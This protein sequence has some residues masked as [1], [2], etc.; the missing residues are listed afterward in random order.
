[1]K[2]IIILLFCFVYSIF[3]N[4]NEVGCL[5]DRWSEIE[6]DKAAKVFDEK[7]DLDKDRRNYSCDGYL[8]ASVI[9]DFLSKLKKATSERDVNKVAKMVRYPVNIGLDE[10]FIDKNGHQKHKSF[11][12]INE[13][14]FVNHYEEIMTEG[15]KDIIQCS[16]LSNMFVMPSQG[17]LM[18]NGELIFSRN[19]NIEDQ[20]VINIVSITSGVESHKK[21]LAKHCTFEK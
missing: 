10:T 17:I 15:V 21:W 8:T 20:V 19:F 5:K 1:M 16:S 4:A 2:K 9:S 12:V 18:A 3:A 6:S 7:Y 14:Q 11:A 13:E